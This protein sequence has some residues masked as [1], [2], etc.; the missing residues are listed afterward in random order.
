MKRRESRTHARRP[1]SGGP[2]NFVFALL[3]DARCRDGVFA[4][5]VGAERSGAAHDIARDDGVGFERGS[6]TGEGHVVD[7]GLEVDGQGVADDGEAVV[8]VGERGLRGK[9]RGREGE[10]E[11]SALI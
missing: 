2:G 1:K 8:V 4:T 6:G 11:G 3:V 7:A 10:Q 5:G 9:S